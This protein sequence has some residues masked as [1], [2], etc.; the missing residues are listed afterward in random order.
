MTKIPTFDWTKD[1]PDFAGIG[2]EVTLQQDEPR[3][4]KDKD[5][6]KTLFPSDSSRYVLDAVSGEPFKY[7][8][9]KFLMGTTDMLQFAGVRR[10]DPFCYKNPAT[11]F[12][13]GPDAFTRATGDV[14]SEKYLKMWND[15]R[16]ER[17]K[18]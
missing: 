1:S 12:F 17:L 18:N 8:G 9:K 15:R 6:Y 2:G 3:I 4:K 11:Y 5:I 14:L 16:A 10:S 13:S 7:R